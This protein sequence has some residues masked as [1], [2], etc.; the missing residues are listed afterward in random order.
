MPKL[1]KSIILLII[2]LLSVLACDLPNGTEE[3][4][5]LPQGVLFQD[6]FSDPTSGWPE[7]NTESGYTGYDQS[8]YR[9]FVTVPSFDIWA[10]PGLSLTDVSIEV[11]ATKISGDDNNDFGI[12]CRHVDP[13]N[14]YVVLISSDGFYGFF[15]SINGSD[16]TLLGMEQMQT[17]EAINQGDADNHLRVDCIDNEIILFINGVMIAQ[18]Q[19]SVLAS[20]DVGLMAGTFETPGTDILFDNFVV[21][22]PE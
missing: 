10:T 6:D 2:L 1:V 3:A 18:I 22:T 17:T 19:D 12:I 20:G 9:I 21:N 15:K 13:E 11:D 8:G 16:L 14:F 5:T 7:S 4:S